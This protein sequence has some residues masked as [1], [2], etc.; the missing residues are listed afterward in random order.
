[1]DYCSRITTVMSV[2]YFLTVSIGVDSV[3]VHGY[4]VLLKKILME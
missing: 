1:M 3:H 4:R 2:S